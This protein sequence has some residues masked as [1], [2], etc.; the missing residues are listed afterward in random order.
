M[1]SEQIR[2]RARWT[3]ADY[4]AYI[5]GWYATKFPGRGKQ[6]E[7]IE[8]CRSELGAIEC[9]DRAQQNLMRIARRAEFIVVY[10]QGKREANR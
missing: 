7:E 4:S 8:Q 2:P 3:T 10:E 1:T 9:R 5:E 6:P